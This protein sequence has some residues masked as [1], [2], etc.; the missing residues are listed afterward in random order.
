MTQPSSSPSPSANELLKLASP[1]L[2][3][4]IA[5]TL[6]DAQLDRFS[7]DDTQFLKFHGIYQ[8]D[9]RDLRKTGKQYMM[10]IRVRVP[11]GVLTPAQYLELDRLSDTHANGTLRITTRQTIQFHGVLK[12]SLAAT[13]RGINDALLTTLATC[14]DVVRNIVAPASPGYG[15]VG[16]QLLAEAH[17]LSE[18]FSPARTAYHA[19]WL[20]GKQ[21]ELSEGEPELDPL[22]G[23]AYL[24]RKFKIALALP[25]VNDTD[26]LTN[27]VGLIAILENGKLVGYNF[28]AGGGMG[29]SHGKPETF[30][31]IADIF[32]FITPEQVEKVLQA[33]VE[34]HRDFGDRANRRHARLKYVIADRGV[35]WF[36][37]ELQRRSGVRLQPVR[38]AGFTAQADP[39]GWHTQP[40]G[41]RF[42]GL[43]VETGRIKD[44]E[45]LRMKAAFREIVRRFGPEVRL[46]P[47]GNILFANIRPEDEPEIAALLAAHGVPSPEQISAVRRA[48]NACVSL[49]TCGL[50]LAESE[51][52][53]PRVLGRIEAL[54]A[55]AGLPDEEIVVRIAGCPN[56]CSR[57]YMAEIALVGKAPGKYQLYLGGNVEGTRLNRV[58]KEMVKEGEEL[59]A[60]LRSL[61]TRFAGERLAG[62]RFGDWAARVVLNEQPAS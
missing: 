53:F 20:D 52:A 21:L 48:S 50:A 41:R 56:G 34:I 47:G 15:D 39:M 60:E 5:E 46:T 11:G 31:R 51:R 61:F 22:Y 38:E 28:A 3:G 17:R 6:A 1:T 10:L 55:E 45:G 57:P 43:F 44:V 59:D 33:T 13:I 54:L 62:E 58:W 23:K 12:S 18:Y 4:T 16:A 25:P 14:G 40:D 35:D 26:V 29:R 49:P 32:G 8:Q 19:I 7:D 42:L 2:A 27:D 36:R 37:E 9:D 30:P 24:P